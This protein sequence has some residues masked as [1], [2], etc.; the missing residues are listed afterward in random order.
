MLIALK[1]SVCLFIYLFIF[2]RELVES[3]KSEKERLQDQCVSLEAEVLDNEEKLHQLEASYQR[4]DAARVQTIEELKVVASHWTEKW[5]KVALTLQL[6]QEEIDNLKRKNEV[7]SCKTKSKMYRA[8]LSH[9]SVRRIIWKRESSCGQPKTEVTPFKPIQ[10]PLLTQPI[11]HVASCR[12]P[13]TGL[14]SN[15]VFSS[16]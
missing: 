10:R 12:S 2:A 11:V 4:Q 7:R 16:Y 14:Y 1:F 5:Q 3:L 8:L 15:F 6:T 13:P 9:M